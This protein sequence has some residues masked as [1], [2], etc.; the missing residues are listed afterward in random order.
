[1]SVWVEDDGMTV[2]REA[3]GGQFELNTFLSFDR[4]PQQAH[5]SAIN[6]AARHDLKI[7]HSYHQLLTG[8]TSYTS[9][10]APA[11]APK[12][13]L[14]T[15]PQLIAHY[16]H[17]S[18]VSTSQSDP[19]SSSI[20]TYLICSATLPVRGIAICVPARGIP[21]GLRRPT[22]SVGRP[23]RSRRGVQRGQAQGRHAPPQ[24]H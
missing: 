21:R 22:P 19:S 11:A 13:P 15:V 12:P 6:L 24:G 2:G 16:L 5:P 18:G 9:T 4:I 10:M 3:E 1:M 20:R 8:T 14:P 23:A 17:A 7:P